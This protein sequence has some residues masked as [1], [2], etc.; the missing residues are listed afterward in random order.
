MA[1]LSPMTA[2]VFEQGPI[3]W[4]EKNSNLEKDEIKTSQIKTQAENRSPESGEPQP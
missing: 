4:G 1:R 2:L 3:T